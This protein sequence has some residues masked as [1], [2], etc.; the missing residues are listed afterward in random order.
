[1]INKVVA[2]CRVS[3][4]QMD[5]VN[6]L[7]NQKYYF[8]TY[9][10]TKKDWQLIQIY[11]DEGITGTSVEKRVAFM[12]MME[13][14]K[15]K[16]FDYIIT[17]EI[18]RFAR[19]TLDSIY[20]TRMLKQYGIGVIFINDN[21]NTLDGDSELRLTLMASIAQEESRKTS[22]RVKW[23]QRLRM[24]QGVVFGHGLFGYDIVNGKLHIRELE[25]KVVQQIF[26]QFVIEKKGT[27]SIAK[28][29]RNHSTIVG[30]YMNQWSATMVSRILKNE[31]YCGDLL[32][33]KTYTP[34]Y[35]TH[36][37]KKNEGEMETILCENH[38][39]AIVSREIY[40]EAQKEMERRKRKKTMNCAKNH[41]FSG[42]IFCSKCGT[43]FYCRSKKR[44]D[45]ST[46][47]FWRSCKEGCE[48]CRGFIIREDELKRIIKEVWKQV[49]IDR[50]GIINQVKQSL[51]EQK[52]RKHNDE[53]EHKT[54]L[55][56]K[57]H[58]KR[59]LELYMEGYIN[60]DELKEK[61]IQTK[62]QTE[63]FPKKWDE[64]EV[65]EIIKPILEGREWNEGFYHSC[66]KR[67]NVMGK[68]T[69]FISFSCTNLVYEVHC[70]DSN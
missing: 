21:I 37:K 38:H 70:E 64:E 32:Q 67:I 41:C 55:Q 25:A 22:E 53:K 12:S 2:Y 4:D 19:N 26:Y 29:L 59:L 11:S 49:D 44:A 14:A 65:I 20:Y 48:Y 5:Q 45:G 58:K 7:E 68:Y 54:S 34:N 40:E 30:T 56:Y 46:Y 50:Q 6:S 63:V 35:L 28:E 16:E 18:S 61:F 47:Y 3:T 39:P 52:D 43:K 42:K 10:R 23:G 1:M 27:H 31:K 62:R 36:K 33:Q 8:E 15:R 13:S 69:Y 17:K 9:I 51:L 60:K 66:V 24:E 57:L